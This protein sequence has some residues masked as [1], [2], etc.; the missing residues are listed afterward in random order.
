MFYHWTSQDTPWS[1]KYWNKTAIRNHAWPNPRGQ[2]HCEGPYRHWREWQES[3][4]TSKSLHK[5]RDSA[6]VQQIPTPEIVSCIEQLK[7][8]ASEIPA[9]D[10]ELEI[11]LLIGSNCPNALVPLSVPNEGDDPFALR[12]KH[13][14]TVRGPLHLRTKPLTNKVTAN[15]ITVRE[16]ESVKEI[17]TPKSLL[18]LFELDFNNKA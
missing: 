16:V 13:G 8:I 4:W 1:S 11:G 3:R 10:P 9:Y 6:E 17:I 14:W 5:T 18:N 2:R 12:L 7:E 15:R